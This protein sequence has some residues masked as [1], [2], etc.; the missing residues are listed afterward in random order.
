[1]TVTHQDGGVLDTTSAE[2]IVVN[3][4]M[5]GDYTVV[6]SDEL[7]LTALEATQVRRRIQRPNHAIYWVQVSPETGEV[8][9]NG[10]PLNGSPLNFRRPE[11]DVKLGIPVTRLI[12]SNYRDTGVAADMESFVGRG[13]RGVS[14]NFE[15]TLEFEGPGD[16]TLRELLQDWLTAITRHLQTGE[17]AQGLRVHDQLPF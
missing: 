8:R 11:V 17:L 13:V 5:D 4:L 15:T 2:L 10:S 12:I 3:R 6:E 14:A 1:M 9:L 16:K 7:K